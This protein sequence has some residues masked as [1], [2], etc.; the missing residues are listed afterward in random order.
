MNFWIT[1]PGNQLLFLTPLIA[2]SGGKWQCDDNGLT[3]L[4]MSDRIL[5]EGD[6]P[7]TR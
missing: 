1:L 7:W 5:L 6:L 2:H 3:Y 4:A